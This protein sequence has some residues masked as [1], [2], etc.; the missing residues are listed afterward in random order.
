MKFRITSVSAALTVSA[1]ILAGC[2]SS[3]SSSSR[4]SAAVTSQE[5]AAVTSAVTA[6]ATAQPKPTA[7]DGSYDTGVFSVAQ[8]DGW[9]IAPVPDSLKKFDGKTNPNSVYAIK[10][11]KEDSDV[12]SCPYL[13]ITWYPKGNYVSSKG[14]YDNVKDLDPVTIGGRDWT[15]FSFSS[16]DTPGISI[17]AREGDGQWVVM[18]STERTNS[19]ISLEDADVKAI[20]ES[21]KL[22]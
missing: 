22:D 9:G 14:F 18:L 10:G 1:A 8:P 17:E 11:G 2:G 16:M 7:S 15:G 12:I 4:A 5:T 19:K 13:W 6:A 21:I 20:I 3:D